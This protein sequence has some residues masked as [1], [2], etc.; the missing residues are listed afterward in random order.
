MH[1][2]HNKPTTTTTVML[3]VSNNDEKFVNGI[4]GPTS[5]HDSIDNRIASHRIH[6]VD[7]D[8]GCDDG[9]DDDGCRRFERKTM[10]SMMMMMMMI[11]NWCC[12]CCFSPPFSFCCVMLC[13][14][15]S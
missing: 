15:Y 13:L 11:I 8:D 3:P 10:P 5:V 6:H 1:H 14:P 9:C 12:G 4:L 2:N 7:T